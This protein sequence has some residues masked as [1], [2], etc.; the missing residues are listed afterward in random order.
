MKIPEPAR[1]GL[2]A[3]ELHTELDQ[4]DPFRRVLRKWSWIMESPRVSPFLKKR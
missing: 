4:G 3:L 1:A 2:T